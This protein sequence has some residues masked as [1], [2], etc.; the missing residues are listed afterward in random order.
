[1]ARNKSKIVAK[2]KEVVIERPKNLMDKLFNLSHSG[3][4]LMHEIWTGV[5]GFIGTAFLVF[6]VSKMFASAYPQN[7][8]LEQIIALGTL[9]TMAIVNI[10]QGFW[11]NLPYILVPSISSMMVLL[12]FS[13]Q[14]MDTPLMMLGLLFMGGVI[15]LVVSIMPFAKKFLD[16]IPTSLRYAAVIGIGVML[17]MMGLSAGGVITSSLGIGGV[18]G[19]TLTDASMLSPLG[20]M[21]DL[22]DARF[23]VF[24][25]G[26]ISLGYFIHKK[27]KNAQLYTIII[28]VLL[29]FV[30]KSEVLGAMSTS[31]ITPIPNFS[32]VF[33]Y[34]GLVNIPNFAEWFGAYFAKFNL[35]TIF[36]NSIWAVFAFITM[37]LSKDI[38]A[39]S[40][41][42]FSL[43]KLEGRHLE[44]EANFKR[45]ERSFQVQGFGRII[46]AL[47][48][49]APV[50]VS[51]ESAIT[52]ANGG[53]T[54]LTTVVYGACALLGIFLIPIFRIIPAIA[55]APVLIYFGIMLFKN[56]DHINWKNI[57][58]SLPAILVVGITL[59]TWNLA[60][61]MIAGIFAY[62]A[63]RIAVWKFDDIPTG[64]WV[65][66]ALGSVAAFLFYIR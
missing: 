48:A 36:T 19:K 58:E 31:N 7:G 51:P 63:I 16:S 15:F 2:T 21:A 37:M 29:G 27:Q 20:S 38:I 42:L 61:G 39:K 62:L 35:I 23:I 30:L 14:T 24:V 33:S 17:V 6:I 60:F 56:A 8:N 64:L 40:G 66:G 1:M 10:A 4:N 44:T 11:S 34:E 46:S 13:A 53:R 22:I 18:T 54:G 43:A 5:F 3:S 45:S 50:E 12:T 57:E 47:F 26:V 32:S 65:L 28:A 9:M 25:I 59:F 52:V 41:I 55:V 49:G